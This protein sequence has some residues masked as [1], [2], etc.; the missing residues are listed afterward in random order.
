[1]VKILC[2]CMLPLFLFLPLSGIKRIKARCER[3]IDGDTVEVIY[4]NRPLKIRLAFIDAPE[5]AQLSF[6]RKPI[7]TWSKLFL[8]KHCFKKKVV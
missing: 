3:V 2:L 1:M 4:N 7:G 8:Q 6:D 5:L